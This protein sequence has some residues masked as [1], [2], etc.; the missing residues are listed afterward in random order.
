MDEY[1]AG[2]ALLI[3][4]ASCGFIIGVVAIINKSQ[5]PVVENS[6]VYT[7]K[8]SSFVGKVARDGKDYYVWSEDGKVVMMEVK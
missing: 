8:S 2:L 7:Y 1:L 3:L 4:G 6:S 5:P